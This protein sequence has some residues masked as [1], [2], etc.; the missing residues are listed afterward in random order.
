MAGRITAGYSNALI[1][2]W[3]LNK[4]VVILQTAFSDTFSDKIFVFWFKF[5]VPEKPIDNKVG[6]VQEMAWR[7]TDK[8]LSES[9]LTNKQVNTNHNPL[10]TD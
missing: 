5:P 7:Q 2:T 6:M 3:G 8:P 10:I 1:N 4:M 9:M